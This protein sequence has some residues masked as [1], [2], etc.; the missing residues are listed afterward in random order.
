MTLHYQTD[1]KKLSCYM[2]SI[3]NTNSNK[4]GLGDM[5]LTEGLINSIER[6]L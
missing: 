5:F 3:W 2:Y 1:W 6:R 4:K